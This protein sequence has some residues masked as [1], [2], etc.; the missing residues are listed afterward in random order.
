MKKII[1]RKFLSDCLI[2][3]LITLVS[4]SVIIWIFQAVN[5]LD[6]IIDDGRSYNIYLNY[7]LLN[8]PKIISKILPFAFFFSF[9]YV[10]AKY[11]LNNQLLIYWN[12]GINKFSFVNFF[13]LFSI[14][15]FLIQIIFTAFIVPKSQSLARTII[16]TSSYDFS[17]N[18]LKAKKFNA[19]TNGLTI[20]AQDKDKNGNLKN[21]YIKR[22][23]GKNNFQITYAKK[24]VFINKVLF[25]ELNRIE[26][27]GISQKFD[28]FRGS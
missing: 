27:N 22:D 18:L 4:T 13:L 3:F 10:I 8:F 25:I 23:S 9:T 16:R 12:F 20:Y 1:F 26:G 28:E 7:A 11:E 2:F 24:G 15:L 6:I 17:Q 5:Y 21:I 14:F 19:A